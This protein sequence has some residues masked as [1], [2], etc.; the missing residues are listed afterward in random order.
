MNERHDEIQENLPAFVLGGL[1]PGEEAEVREHLRGCK[2]CRRE[3]AS[4]ESLTHALVLTAPEVPLPVG[5]R[6]RMLERTES[7]RALPADPGREQHPRRPFRLLQT[8]AAA[9]LLVAVLIGGFLLQQNRQLSSEVATK[10][11]TINEVVDLMERADLRVVNLE[12]PQSEVRGRVYAAREGD[13]GM[14][15]FDQLPSPPEGE[16]YQLWVGGDEDLE[17]AGTF[18]PTDIEKGSYH[19]LI[20][21]SGGF[22]QYEYV[23][24]TAS[25][26][27]GFEEAPPASDPA[28]VLQSELPSEVQASRI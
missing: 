5:S 12:T 27:G 16:V 7:V 28:W 18:A 14:F 11:Q 22:D 10:Q 23:G 21:P 26:E 19:K 8:L 9:S 6:K 15:V 2:E 13:V 25:P 3:A 4:Y 24:I 17:S 1:E 20:R